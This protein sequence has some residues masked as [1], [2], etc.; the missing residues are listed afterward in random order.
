MRIPR[1]LGAVDGKRVH[2]EYFYAHLAYAPFQDMQVHE[3]NPARPVRRA[4]PRIVPG[5]IGIWIGI[6]PF[7]LHEKVPRVRAYHRNRITGQIIRLAIGDV[8]LKALEIAMDA[9]IGEKRG[10]GGYGNLRA[11]GRKGDFAERQ[12]AVFRIGRCYPKAAVV[13]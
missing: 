2:G 4:M 10:L 7:I 12:G 1:G 13:Y 8:F 5:F 9:V 11:V 3:P 6:K